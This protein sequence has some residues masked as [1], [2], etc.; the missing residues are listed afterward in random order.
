MHTD[1][2]ARSRTFCRSS[3]ASLLVDTCAAR[4]VQPVRPLRT[5][6]ARSRTP[7]RSSTV[8]SCTWQTTLSIPCVA[9]RSTKTHALS[10]NP[11]LHSD[12]RQLFLRG[13]LYHHGQLGRRLSA[14]LVLPQS[15]HRYTA[16][17]IGPA[18]FF[19]PAKPV[20]RRALEISISTLDAQLNFRHGLFGEAHLDNWHWDL[21]QIQSS[22]GPLV[23]PCKH[24]Y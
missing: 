15:P 23:L 12:H 6:I 14:S 18:L 21:Q 19:S 10:T 7:C 5:C 17:D 24:T 9:T 2:T 1:S 22:L 8:I 13:R 4:L 16:C 20:K 3:I 11:P